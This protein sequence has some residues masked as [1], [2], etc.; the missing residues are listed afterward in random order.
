MI[1]FLEEF[2]F[3]LLVVFPDTEITISLDI[4]GRLIYI[5][6]IYVVKNIAICIDI[7][8]QEMLESVCIHGM[9]ISFIFYTG[10]HRWCLFFVFVCLNEKK[11]KPHNEHLTCVITSISPALFP[12]YTMLANATFLLPWKYSLITTVRRSLFLS[13]Y[14]YHFYTKNNWHTIGRI[15]K[16]LSVHKW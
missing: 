16:I 13:Y 11:N 4:V 6:I 15:L 1:F 3:T 10:T 5:S 12:C 8:C 9:W 2:V 7:K 14:S